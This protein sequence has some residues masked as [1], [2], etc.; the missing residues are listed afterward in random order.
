[1]LT[2]PLCFSP[3]QAGLGPTHQIIK[4]A[5]AAGFTNAHDFLVHNRWAR[6]KGGA[7]QSGRVECAG[8]VGA[9]VGVGWN[10]VQG[11]AVVG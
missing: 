5:R 2:F 1:M 3:L 4:E 6:P 11:L 10:G 8:S 7:G 9:G